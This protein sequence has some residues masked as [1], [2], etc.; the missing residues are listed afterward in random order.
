MN[1]K[2]ESTM[3]AN[4]ISTVVCPACG[5]PLDDTNKSSGNCSYCQTKWVNN[6]P[7]PN[8][9]NPLYQPFSTFGP[10]SLSTD[11]TSTSVLFGGTYQHD[12]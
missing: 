1:K 12:K 4:N 9:L 8:F 5:A 7:M 3:D 11:N 6:S 10:P 2:E